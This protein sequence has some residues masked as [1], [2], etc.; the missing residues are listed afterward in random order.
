MGMQMLRLNPE[1][2]SKDPFLFSRLCALPLSRGEVSHRR[3]MQWLPQTCASKS[4]F[5]QADGQGTGR[6][7]Q[8]LTHKGPSVCRLRLFLELDP[9]KSLEDPHEAAARRLNSKSQ[10]G[11]SS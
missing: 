7:E 8:Y 5:L 10:A 4:I 2:Q 1:Q 11:V 6:V 9:C 3:A